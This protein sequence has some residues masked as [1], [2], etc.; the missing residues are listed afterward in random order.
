[1]NQVTIAEWVRFYRG[2]ITPEYRAAFIMGF[3]RD[4][5]PALLSALGIS[6]AMDLIVSFN[7]KESG[8]ANK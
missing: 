1:M 7:R 2:I 4:Q 6:S 8:N 5:L 3:E